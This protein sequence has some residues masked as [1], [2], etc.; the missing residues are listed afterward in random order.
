MPTHYQQHGFILKTRQSQQMLNRKRQDASKIIVILKRR[1]QDQQQHHMEP[2]ARK[3]R[4]GNPSNHLTCKSLP[5]KH[6]LAADNTAK[7]KFDGLITELE[8]SYDWL[9]TINVVYTSLRQTYNKS[10]WSIEQQGNVTRLCDMEKELLIAYDDLNLQIN[11]LE[12][13]R[14]QYGAK[15]DTTESNVE[16]E[17]E[18][19]DHC[20]HACCAELT[21]LL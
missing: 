2:S 6:T 14:H 21:P 13:K 8:S 16:R 3:K 7:S 5:K 15:T 9:A 10:K 11:Q 12:K 17:R 18:R 1:L 20:L 4:R 19:W